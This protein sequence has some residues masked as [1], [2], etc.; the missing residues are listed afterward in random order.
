MNEI[1]KLNGR[2]FIPLCDLLKAV[3]ACQTGGHAKLEIGEGLVKVNGA[4]ELRKRCK[5]RE[6]QIVEYGDYKITV[7]NS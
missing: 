7:V 6:N 2:E 5:I 3:G 1:F 4:E